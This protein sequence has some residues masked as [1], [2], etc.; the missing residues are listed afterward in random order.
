[1]GYRENL[2]VR[3]KIIVAHETPPPRRPDPRQQAERASLLVRLPQC[4]SLSFR[5]RSGHLLGRQQLTAAPFRCLGLR[6]SKLDD[7]PL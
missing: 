7:L 3:L 1:M 2:S 5:R 4:R 6:R